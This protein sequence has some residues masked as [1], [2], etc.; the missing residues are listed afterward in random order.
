MLALE[1]QTKVFLSTG[2]Q[3]N[4]LLQIIFDSFGIANG[5]SKR[6]VHPFKHNKNNKNKYFT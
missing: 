6:E 1:A 3:H 2:K 5:F 4:V